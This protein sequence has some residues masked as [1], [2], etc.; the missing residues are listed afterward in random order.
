MKAL[1]KAGRLILL[2]F[3]LAVAVQGSAKAQGTTTNYTFTMKGVS[4]TL[5]HQNFNFTASGT[6][7]WNAT[8][9]AATFHVA[10]SAGA[11][12]EGAGTLAYSAKGSYAATTFD[13]PASGATGLAVFS[14][15]FNKDRSKFIGTF[16][17]ASPNR[18]GPAPGGFVFTTGN[19]TAAL[20]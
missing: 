12:F 14:G 2:G 4:T 3:V 5:A 9:G 17:A 20:K 11:A 16:Q 15:A 10:T 6:M 1:M 19:V 8:T 13:S 18:L 7:T